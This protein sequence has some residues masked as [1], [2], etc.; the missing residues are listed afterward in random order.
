MNLMQAVLDRAKGV[1][2]AFWQVSAAPAQAVRG[3]GQQ[4]TGLPFL[5]AVTGTA[6]L[7]LVDWPV[8]L[9]VA[10]GYL[11]VRKQPDQPDPAMPT[12]TTEQ[13]LLDHPPV[14]NSA[15]ASAA[16]RGS[17]APR[18]ASTPAPATRRTAPRQTSNPRR[19]P[20]GRRPARPGTA[21]SARVPDPAAATA[22]ARSAAA[23]PEPWPG[24][25]ALT[26]PRV[27][28]R[29]DDSAVDLVAVSRYEAEHRNRK[30]VQAAVA[31]RRSSPHL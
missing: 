3:R 27:L 9:L 10:G 21:A 30:M 2:E 16:D 8:A 15:A 7:G 19:S 6:A 20:A 23:L 28:Q 12:T 11:L 24:Y 5:A 26:V 13:P 18:R 25:A 31:A 14:A 17:A 22:P 29:L 4:R 1:P